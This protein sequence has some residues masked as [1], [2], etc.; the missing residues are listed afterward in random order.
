M[1]WNEGTRIGEERAVEV[2]RWSPVGQFALLFMFA[3]VIGMIAAIVMVLVGP[4]A[5]GHTYGPTHCSSVLSAPDPDPGYFHD[6]D[7][8]SA[9][10]VAWSRRT[11][12][13]VVT[14]A[15][16]ILALMLGFL[17]AYWHNRRVAVA[18][19]RAQV[20]RASNRPWS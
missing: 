12:E 3:G 17:I 19:Y 1:A 8:G 16:S 7:S 6:G 15:G 18:R 4:T 14:L 2:A 5:G 20:A 11:G 13:A 10:D 9:C